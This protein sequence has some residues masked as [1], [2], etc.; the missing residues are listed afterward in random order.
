MSEEN[1]ELVRRFFERLNVGEL[2]PECC[3]PE[4][5]IRNWAHSPMPGP[6]RGHEGLLRWWGD[7]SE[8]FED[9][10]LE[11]KE[12]VDVDDERVVTVQ[13]IIGSFRHTGI[14]LDAAW[15]SVIGVR[16]RLIVSAVGYSS[17][18]EAKRAAGLSE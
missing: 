16:E 2:S 1:V 8:A 14:R 9:V 18:Q 10:R 4:I 15:G 17:P 11:L 5:E 13:R 7:L 3:D 6:Y 12:V